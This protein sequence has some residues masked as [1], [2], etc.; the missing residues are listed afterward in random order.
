MIKKHKTPNQ[1]ANLNRSLFRKIKETN[2]QRYLG[3]I[4]NIVVQ[5]ILKRYHGVIVN[6]PRHD[7]GIAVTRRTVFLSGMCA[8]VI[9]SKALC[10]TLLISNN[11]REWVRES[12]WQICPLLNPGEGCSRGVCCRWGLFQVRVV[13]GG[14]VVLRG[15][16]FRME[17]FSRWTVVLDEDC[18]RWGLLQVEGCSRWRQLF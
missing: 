8:S 1:E 11:E 16:L 7:N 15:G 10:Y 18:S 14:S 12:N 5:L 4:G 17:G 3:T 2:L 13:P 6:F 9:R